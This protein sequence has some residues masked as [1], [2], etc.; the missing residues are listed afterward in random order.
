VPDAV[1]ATPATPADPAPDGGAEPPVAAAG[2][3]AAVL[4]ADGPD[5]LPAGPDDPPA[6]GGA[7]GRTVVGAAV[8]VVVRGCGAGGGGAA[9]GSFPAQIDA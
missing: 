6:A 3:G 2:S 8:D 4:A 1:V 9:T 5:A 7:V